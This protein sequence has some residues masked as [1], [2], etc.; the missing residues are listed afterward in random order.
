MLTIFQRALL[1]LSWICFVSGNYSKDV[2]APNLN[3]VNDGVKITKIYV[4]LKLN[5]STVS[6]EPLQNEDDPHKCDDPETCKNGGKCVEAGKDFTCDCA[7][8]FTGKDCSGTVWCEKYGGKLCGKVP[9]KYNPDLNRTFCD[10]GEAQYF[11]VK[12][13][14]CIKINECL[15]LQLDGK[16]LSLHEKCQKGTCSCE[17]GYEYTKN[18]ETC[19]RKNMCTDDNKKKSCS[20]IAALC[21]EDLDADNGFKCICDDG[22]DRDKFKNGTCTHKCNLESKHRKMFA[23]S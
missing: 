9:C 18:N 6:D 11:D 8:E 13:K 1:G 15:K 2:P 3:Y 7:N 12:N 20:E 5:I 22:Y 19:V 23:K 4:P 10:C 16:C 14:E 21:E 17:K